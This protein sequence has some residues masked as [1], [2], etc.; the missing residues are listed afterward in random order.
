MIG[1]AHHS[2]SAP[3]A[4][5]GNRWGSGAASGTLL[6]LD[7]EQPNTLA[8]LLKVDDANGID[9]GG[10]GHRGGLTGLIDKALEA[11]ALVEGL[12]ELLGMVVDDAKE[13]P[14]MLKVV[15]G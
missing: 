2:T 12:D 15:F 3:C 9:V 6:D 7:D 13:L 1:W 11:N 4:L 14:P 5:V 10:G 8:H